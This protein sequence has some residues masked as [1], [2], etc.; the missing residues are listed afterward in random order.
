M[1]KTSHHY[2]LVKANTKK[3]TT[4]ELAAKPHWWRI[5]TDGGC[6]DSGKGTESGVVG[7]GCYIEEIYADGN[8][9]HVASLWGP[10]V[11]DHESRYG[12]CSIAAQSCSSHA[13]YLSLPV[14]LISV[15][16]YLKFIFT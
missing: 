16:R 14:P 10:V 8:W 12:S 7:W 5:Y 15:L 1:G 9:V 3:E 13:A 2:E 11:T 4:V 6:T